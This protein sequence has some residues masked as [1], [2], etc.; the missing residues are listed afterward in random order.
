VPFQRFQDILDYHS[1]TEDAGRTAAKANV[2]TL[3]LTHVVP[4]P[5]PGGEADCV[6]EAAAHFGGTVLLP[7]D[8]DVIHVNPE[9]A[10]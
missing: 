5:Q 7:D 2:G 9:G 10:R 1:S 3:V 8:L 6:A 4:A